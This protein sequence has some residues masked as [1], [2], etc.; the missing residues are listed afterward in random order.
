MSG[1]DTSSSSSPHTGQSVKR[2]DRRIKDGETISDDGAMEP[3]ACE[4]PDME[5][6][7][8]GLVPDRLDERSKIMF[9]DSANS[10]KVSGMPKAADRASLR[11]ICIVD[12]ARWRIW[13]A[14]MH[15]VK[16]ACCPRVPDGLFDKQE[17]FAYLLADV[18]RGP[19]LLPGEAARIVGQSAD[20]AVAKAK[21]LLKVKT[22]E[23]LYRIVASPSAAAAAHLETLYELKMPDAEAGRKRPATFWA[24]RQLQ[25]ATNKSARAMADAKM[26]GER[27]QVLSD[28][29]RAAYAKAIRLLND[30]SYSDRAV[31][32]AV[33][34]SDKLDAELEEARRAAQEAA[35]AE[36]EAA[37]AREAAAKAAAEIAAQAAAQQEAAESEGEE[38]WMW[39]DKESPT[40]LAR[41]LLR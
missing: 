22:N 40:E 19:R 11:V 41:L 29:C 15:D 14:R 7:H 28:A 33:T 20:N 9:L 30:R 38:G 18:L 8:S 6:D 1:V 34:K 4:Q 10:P 12:E 26:A 17:L 16:A 5:T 36:A 39:C 35:A 24:G 31:D 2:R 3:D 32:S 25:S 13:K 23:A 27:E 21:R 37:E